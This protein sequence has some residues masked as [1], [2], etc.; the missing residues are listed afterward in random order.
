MIDCICQNCHKSTTAISSSLQSADDDAV[1]LLA[2]AYKQV[3]QTGLH[4][5][6]VAV[7]VQSAAN[8]PG[9]HM[10]STASVER[11]F[12]KLSVVKSKLRSTVAQGRLEA[13]ILASV[14]RDILNQS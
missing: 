9:H 14:E 13:L 10:Q 2:E 5:A 7:A 4:S 1:D 12:S 6:K 3:P 8:T 11:G